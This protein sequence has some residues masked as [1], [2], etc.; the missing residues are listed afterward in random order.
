M[1]TILKKENYNHLDIPDDV[2]IEDFTNASSEDAIKFSEWYFAQTQKRISTL[3]EYIIITKGNFKLDYTDESLITL[4]SWFE[5]NLE[6]VDKTETELEY[7]KS[8]TS[9]IYWDKIITKRISH[10]MIEIAIDISYYFVDMLLNNFPKLHTDC[11][12]KPKWKNNLKKPVI[13]GFF[14]DI[15]LYPI[16]LLIECAQRS[17]KAKNP[18]RLKMTY[19]KY[20]TFACNPFEINNDNDYPY[21]R[22]APYLETGK[23]D[24][25]NANKKTADKFYNEYIKLADDR[26]NALFNKINVKNVIIKRDYTPES[27]I[28]LCD[29]L[30]EN[31]KYRELTKNEII[32]NNIDL[33]PQYRNNNCSQNLDLILTNSSVQLLIDASF[34]FAEVILRN[35]KDSYWSYFTNGK[36]DVDVNQPVI[37]NSSNKN[38]AIS[39][40]R[41]FFNASYHFSRTHIKD[42]T[43][44]YDAYISLSNIQ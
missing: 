3:Q 37:M 22:I 40:I 33:G 25:S 20:A 28:P 43:Y 42:S 6:I 27:L 19:D 10:L 29:W 41:P 18:C 23:L 8:R 14:M 39:P 2:F 44:I 31:L 30:L 1:S 17:I 34:Y 24:F 13:S 26:L 4:W 12:T 16:E 32:E 15:T 36:N 5:S 9:P 21:W 38:I 7:E 11:I 35:I